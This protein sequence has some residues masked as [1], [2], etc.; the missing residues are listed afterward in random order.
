MTVINMDNL[1]QSNYALLVR[2]SLTKNTKIT[3]NEIQ[4]EATNTKTR[5]NNILNYSRCNCFKSTLNSRRRKKWSQ[6]HSYFIRNIC[7][8]PDYVSVFYIKRSWITHTLNIECECKSSKWIVV[9]SKY[10]FNTFKMQNNSFER[11]EKKDA[12]FFSLSRFNM[13]CLKQTNVQE[14]IL[15]CRFVSNRVL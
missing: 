13:L 8:V 11:L 12:E 9:N 15:L 3:V 14:T 4:L 6:T 5:K 10:I 1:F 7:I 2:G